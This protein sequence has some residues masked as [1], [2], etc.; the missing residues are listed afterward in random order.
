[1]KKPISLTLFFFIFLSSFLVISI[2]FVD[3]VKATS[4]ITGFEGFSEGS[5]YTST[6]MYSYKR[7]NGN[8][9]ITNNYSRTGSNSFR[10]T[11]KSGSGGGSGVF[12]F[13]YGLDK[14]INNFETWVYITNS[15]G[16]ALQFQFSNGYYLT[17]S[18]WLIAFY[19]TREG[20]KI[21]LT[22]FTPGE[23]HLL[24]LLNFNTWYK[25]GFEM[26]SNDTVKYYTNETIIYDELYND[27]PN[28]RITSFYA[29]SSPGTIQ[30]YYLDDMYFST[31]D[32]NFTDIG[33]TDFS[34]NDYIGTGFKIE[35]SGGV[36]E[37][38]NYIE[39][40]APSKIN[41]TITGFEIQCMPEMYNADPEPS[42]YYIYIKD[43]LLGSGTCFYSSGNYYILQFD[44]SVELELN[45]EYPI[46]ELYHSVTTAYTW[47][48]KYRLQESGLDYYYS[49]SDSNRQD[50]NVNGWY[51]RYRGLF[52]KLFYSNLTSSGANPEYTNQI[53]L[54][55][56]NNHSEYNVPFK[57][58]YSTGLFMVLVDQID[59]PYRIAI[60]HNGTLTN[61]DP[62]FPKDVLF[63]KYTYGFTPEVRGNYTISLQ[64]QN[65]T[66]I[67]NKTF[68]APYVRNNYEIWTE[69]NPSS[70][71]S[72]YRINA[73]IDDTGAYTNYR[74]CIF[75]SIDK[76][77]NEKNAIDT[78]DISK[79]TSTK[80]SYSYLFSHSS[81]YST[82]HYIK[83]F[84]NIGNNQYVGVSGTHTHFIIQNID[85]NDYVYVTKDVVK[86]GEIF[87]IY[88][89][90]NYLGGDVKVFLGD[91][92]IGDVGESNRFAFDYSIDQE[93]F[94]TVYLKVKLSGT[95]QTIG[96]DSITISDEEGN[97]EPSLLPSF[98]A[99][100]GALVGVVVVVVFMM[101]PLLLPLALGFHVAMHPIVYVFSGSLGL[102]LCIYLGLFQIWVVFFI[103]MLSVIALIIMWWQGRN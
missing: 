12:N 85:F 50:G 36:V 41:A 97:V 93:G 74:I 88:G 53:Q 55:N 21:N 58:V 33:C 73:I 68:F 39:V 62:N 72:D 80:Q 77:S 102:S 4:Y 96:M 42:N 16:Y 32:N 35:G 101:L 51:L 11:Y 29:S 94:Y 38:E 99:E 60:Y 14:M 40:K 82:S 26:Y 13:T 17:P 66:A 89:W 87:N 28:K 31:I 43:T 7:P 47:G 44:F 1:M 90:H 25:I 75:D 83:I 6:F 22:Y 81:L 98:P 86:T 49:H 70:M 100:L 54:L 30:G 84:A 34:G 79:S 61:Q 18:N 9:D 20:A 69:P 19:G 95:Y 3:S 37:H 27:L 64:Y 10:S 24:Q 91:Q 52:Y 71:I 8:F 57:N 63:Y 46:I 103:L 67:V 65:G 92:P 23:E 76:V 5:Q 48:L 2:S 56:F 15:D 59:T 78:I 45:N